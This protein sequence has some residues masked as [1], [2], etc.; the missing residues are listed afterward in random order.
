METKDLQNKIIEL[1]SKWD[2]KR[3]VVTG[4]QE[5]FT[6]LIEE[7]GELARQYVNLQQ[8]KK[9][10]NE[11]EVEDAIGDILMMVV[12]LAHLRGLDIEELILKN[13]KEQEKRLEELEE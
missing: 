5:A 9:L 8:R 2:K 13:I 7:V 10:Y 4:E 11:K 6:H 3:K 1:I 12:K